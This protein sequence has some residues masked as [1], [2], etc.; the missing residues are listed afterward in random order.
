VYFNVCSFRLLSLKVYGAELMNDE[1]CINHIVSGGNDLNGLQVMMQ[2]P[3]K[4]RRAKETFVT[5]RES[6]VFRDTMMQKII[7]LFSPIG[8]GQQPPS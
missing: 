2:I 3:E 7:A 1:D 8:A 5:S 6:F 4:L